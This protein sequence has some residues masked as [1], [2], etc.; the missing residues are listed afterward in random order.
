MIDIEKDDDLINQFSQSIPQPFT[1]SPWK[2]DKT[3]DLK[4]TASSYDKLT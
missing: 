1:I 2:N 3:I 4:A